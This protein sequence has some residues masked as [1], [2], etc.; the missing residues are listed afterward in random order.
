MM[1][2]IKMFCLTEKVA[3][4]AVMHGNKCI[5][6]KKMLIIIIEMAII[7]SIMT[8]VDKMKSLSG[9]WSNCGELYCNLV[10]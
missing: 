5:V 9:F 4:N 3:N 6:I 7:I 10:S 8:L 1:C 2:T